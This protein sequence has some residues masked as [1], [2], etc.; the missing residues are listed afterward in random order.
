MSNITPEASKVFWNHHTP[1]HPQLARTPPEIKNFNKV[2]EI[3]PS[4]Q[5]GQ[6]SLWGDVGGVPLLL[7]AR[8]VG[9]LLEWL[10]FLF[11]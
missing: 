8:Y 4:S 1:L 11:E 5:A 3:L 2:T 10:F 6:C 7:F 9:I